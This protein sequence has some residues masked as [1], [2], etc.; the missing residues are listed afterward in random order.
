M[1]CQTLP[2]TLTDFFAEPRA[3][4]KLSVMSVVVLPASYDTLSLRVVLP[5][6][7][8]ARPELPA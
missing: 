4:V 3:T 2:L 6:V 5:H 7:T 8:L 1:S